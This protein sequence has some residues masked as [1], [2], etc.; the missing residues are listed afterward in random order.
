[1]NVS[2]VEAVEV[3]DEDDDDDDDDSAGSLQ[4]DNAHD[5]GMNLVEP[6]AEAPNELHMDLAMEEVPNDTPDEPNP[7][8]ESNASEP[9]FGAIED[10]QLPDSQ[11]PDS[12]VPVPDSRVPDS[13]VPS[14]VE[15]EMET[16]DSP[17]EYEKYTP[18]DKALPYE[19]TGTSEPEPEA[20]MDAE[21]ENKVKDLKAE[22]EKLRQQKAALTLGHIYV[23]VPS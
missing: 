10:S 18:A 23:I 6:E 5:G 9:P 16:V 4:D 14:N 3:S 11:V 22:I 7:V 15:K 13:Q 2:D 8:C 21:S 1:M 12:P 17:G 19:P 20:M